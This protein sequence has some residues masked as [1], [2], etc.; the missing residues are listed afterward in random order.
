MAKRAGDVGTADMIDRERPGARRPVVA[1]H[2]IRVPL[3]RM[4]YDRTSHRGRH[5]TPCADGVRASGVVRREGTNGA[6]TM[7]KQAISRVVSSVGYCRPRGDTALCVTEGTGY[8][9]PPNMVNGE[10]HRS[11][12][13]MTQQAIIAT[14]Q[15]M[16]Y[17][18]T[19]NRCSF[20]TLSTGSIGA[21]GMVCREGMNPSSSMAQQ[22]V[23][24]SICLVRD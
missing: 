8:V 7:A 23:G 1:K 22:T 12:P 5:V 6:G 13:A 14:V 9:G 3:G 10:W 4:R 21:T 11:G 19:R 20:V 15:R 16:R 18:R 24:D 2:A 17:R